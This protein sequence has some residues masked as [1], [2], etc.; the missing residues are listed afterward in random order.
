M[1]Q[2]ISD[3]S[4]SSLFP[5]KPTIHFYPEVEYCPSCRTKLHVR[6]TTQKKTVVTMDIGAF[7]AKETKLECAQCGALYFSEELQKLV[8]NHCTFGFDVIEYVGK[9]LF[10]RSRN[11]L[12]I[13]KELASENITISEREVSFL[14]QKFIIYLALA[15]QESNEKLR[16]SM[17]KR[18]GYILQ[19]DGTCEGSSPHLFCGLDG[20]SKIVLGAI[21][22]PSEKKEELI[23]FFR[24]I[25]EQYG[26]PIAL[27]HDMGGAILAAI[28]VVFPEIA[29][30]ICHFHFLRDIGKDLLSQDY[31]TIMTLLKKFHIRGSLRRKASY[32]KGKI[33]NNTETVIKFRQALEDGNFNSDYLQSVPEVATYLLINWALESTHQS[34]ETT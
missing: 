6:K 13:M 11:N 29:D 5:Q 15:H 2:L 25:K 31:Q 22:T 7:W 19:V 17:L 8:P 27:V 9:A 26:N 20:I 4:T 1:N 34:Q 33:D 3:V 23:P 32:L 14:G 24:G 28:A 30:F 18:G 12:E 10:L 16:L 21:K